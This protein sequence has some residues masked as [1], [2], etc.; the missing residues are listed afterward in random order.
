MILVAVMM[1]ECQKTRGAVN[2][3][4]HESGAEDVIANTKA[5]NRF[6]RFL[7]YISFVGRDSQQPQNA[8]KAPQNQASAGCTQQILLFSSESSGT[9][10][11]K[12]NWFCEPICNLKCP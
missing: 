10:S 3:G 6:E 5:V 7:R 12:P 4:S 11:S 1:N 8:D 2:V 9:S